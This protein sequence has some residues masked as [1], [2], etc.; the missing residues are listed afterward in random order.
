MEIEIEQSQATM[1][2]INMN[3]TGSVDEYGSWGSAFFAYPLLRGRVSDLY[4]A[5]RMR[6]RSSMKIELPQTVLEDP[7]IMPIFFDISSASH[8]FVC[9][10]GS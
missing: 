3:D 6:T 5:R 8:K 1:K 10:D 4:S 7:M 9:P 2:G